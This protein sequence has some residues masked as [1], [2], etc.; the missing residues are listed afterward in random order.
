[1]PVG[2]GRGDRRDS[3]VDGCGGLH[4]AETAQWAG[5]CGMFEI[6]T[7]ENDELGEVERSYYLEVEVTSHVL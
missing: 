7:E 4:Q 1:M 2:H 5:R 6:A 3:T